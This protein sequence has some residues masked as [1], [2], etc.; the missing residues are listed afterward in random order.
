MTT[1]T[2]GDYAFAK[3]DADEYIIIMVINLSSLHHCP[4]P[5]ST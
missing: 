5:V 4:L 1:V 3:H 2:H